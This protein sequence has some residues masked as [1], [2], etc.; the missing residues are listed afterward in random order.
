M[1]VGVCTWVAK[2]LSRL[3]DAAG[4]QGDTG[5][6]TLFDAM[7]GEVWLRGVVSYG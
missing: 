5:L 4:S 6:E 1:P 3:G 2:V 7:K